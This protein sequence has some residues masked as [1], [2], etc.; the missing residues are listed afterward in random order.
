MFFC[1]YRDSTEGTHAILS[2]TD[3]QKES[4]TFTYLT[5]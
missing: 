4:G 3:E 1:F 5:S 2:S